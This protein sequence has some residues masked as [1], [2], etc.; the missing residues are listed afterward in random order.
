MYCRYWQLNRPARPELP[1]YKNAQ[2]ASKWQLTSLRFWTGPLP[3][4]MAWTKKPSMENMARRP[5]LI[6]LT[7]KPWMSG[8]Q[9]RQGHDHSR[10]ISLF[11]RRVCSA[12][13]SSHRAA[14]RHV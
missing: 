6:S 3:V 2:A 10:C 14:P 9:P 12:S 4:A 13:T 5:F 8:C 1:N 11:A 7:Y